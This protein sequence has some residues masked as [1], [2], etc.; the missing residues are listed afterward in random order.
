MWF[1]YRWW[2]RGWFVLAQHDGAW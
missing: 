2:V 1:G